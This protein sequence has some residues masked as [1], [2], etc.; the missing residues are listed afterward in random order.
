M[1]VDLVSYE[2]SSFLRNISFGF[3]KCS[4]SYYV[5]KSVMKDTDPSSYFFSHLEPTAWDWN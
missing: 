5:W 1:L 4:R 3:W 2:I